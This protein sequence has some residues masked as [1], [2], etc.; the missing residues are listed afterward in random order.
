[1]IYS[2]VS[3]E[4]RPI[5][6][7][8]GYAEDHSLWNRLAKSLKLEY[9]VIA[10]DLPGFGK[11]SRLPG[12]FSIDDVA[13]SVQKFLQEELMLTEFLVMGHSLGGYVALS[14]AA[15]YPE[16]VHGFGLINS[17]ALAD[18]PE[19]KANRLKTADF[20]RKYKAPF[21]LENFVPNLFYEDNRH[22][23]TD[24]INTVIEMGKDLDEDLLADYMIA[25]M[26]R[27]ERI[28]LLSEYEHV[29]FIGGEKDTGFTSEDY[30]TQISA[31]NN[32]E[33]AHVLHNVG[34]MSM[35]EAPGE[36]ETLTE[37]FLKSI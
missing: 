26:N 7:L 4:G 25:M 33:N 11:S 27:P 34:H 24:E 16:A 20:I 22:A 1:M 12:K 10:I 13:T 14:L 21:F 8:H 5:V 29:L 2:K 28:N 37:R 19:K 9:K 17:T 6:L 23:L 15:N 31:L 36:L 35:F 30:N 32:N 18:S 3:G